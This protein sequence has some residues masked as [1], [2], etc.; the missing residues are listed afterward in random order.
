MEREQVIRKVINLLKES[1]LTIYD[2]HGYLRKISHH[3][4][5]LLCRV[6]GEEKR[7]PF[8]EGK[9]NNPIG[10]FPFKEDSHYIEFAEVSEC[11]R[12]H[13]D[14][15]GLPTVGFFQEILPLMDEINACL[16]DLKQPVLDG[17]Y[18]ANKQDNLNW[19]VYLSGNDEAEELSV[20]YYGRAETA[21]IRYLG[22]LCKGGVI[23][24]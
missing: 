2:V 9:N 8:E 16:K 23:F 11:T 19:I 10:L 1:G 5:D 20:D 6:D 17:Y 13:A 22:S 12:I 18:F 24:G 21:K 4:F 14:E 15:T 3:Q 7:L